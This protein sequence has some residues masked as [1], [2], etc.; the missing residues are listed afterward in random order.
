MINHIVVKVLRCEKAVVSIIFASPI[1]GVTEDNSD[2]THVTLSD[3][4]ES[5]DILGMVGLTNNNGQLATGGIVGAKG[6]TIPKSISSVILQAMND[7]A[8]VI[9]THVL[10]SHAS[11][12]SNVCA[13]S[14]LILV[15]TRETTATILTHDHPYFVHAPPQQHSIR[16]D[17]LTSL[18]SQ[19]LFGTTQAQQSANDRKIDT[20]LIPSSIQSRGVMTITAPLLDIIVNGIETSFMEGSHC[21]SPYA[22]SLF[23]IDMPRISTRINSSLV[24]SPSYRSA[25]LIL[26]R[27]SKSVL[28]EKG[29]DGEHDKNIVV[30]ACGDAMKLLCMDVP[31]EDM[32]MM[33]NG[34]TPA[35]ATAPHHHPYLNR[36]GALL[37]T[38]CAENIPI[39]WVLEQE[40]ECNWFVENATIIEL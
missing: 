1:K 16:E 21:Q 5:D 12:G 9:L 27:T 30:H 13:S 29:H 33:M 15:P 34:T 26:D 19:H 18:D 11:L 6:S 7:G 8:H 40:S 23:L 32:V 4:L 22:L 36:V 2:V 38:L 20:T 31:A 24:M 39:Q 35:V 28:V 25:T 37:R 10:S 17:D 14:S 3:G